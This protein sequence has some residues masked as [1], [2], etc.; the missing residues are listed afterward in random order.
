M[1]A[2]PLRQ[3]APKTL[4]LEVTNAD[5][6]IDPFQDRLISQG[7][8]VITAQTYDEALKLARSALPALIIVYDD[9][10]TNIDAVH[11]LMLQ[12]CDRIGR[13]AMIPLLILADVSRVAELKFEELPDR[14]VVIQRRAD[15][16]NQLTRTVKRLL[17]VWELE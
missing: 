3:E 13:L 4:F 2:I 17:R 6:A 14:V 11:W 5:L 15:T 1:S 10:A 7:Y 16:L 12:H 8:E 9:P